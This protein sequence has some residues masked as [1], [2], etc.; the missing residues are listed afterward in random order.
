MATV[1]TV[2]Y[3]LGFYTDDNKT[4]SLTVPRAN[5]SL[6]L[7]A[8]QTAMNHMAATTVLDDKNGTATG[9]KYARKVTKAVET[10]L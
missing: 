3:Q 7:G 5:D 6:G 8:V 4:L 9:V 1:N 2:V 10:I